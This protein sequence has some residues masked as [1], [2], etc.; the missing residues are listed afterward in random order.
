MTTLEN[1][2]GGPVEERQRVFTLVGASVACAVIV[3]GTMLSLRSGS[4]R[5]ALTTTPPATVGPATSVAAPI[6]AAATTTATPRTTTAAATD[7]AQRSRVATSSASSSVASTRDAGT[8]DDTT[9]AAA[10]DSCS[11]D[12]RGL[13]PGRT[14]SC[15]FIAREE[16]GWWSGYSDGG[17]AG[18]YQSQPPAAEVRVTHH[19]YTSYYR[20][21]TDPGTPGMDMNGWG[22]DDALIEPGDL[23]E[24]D[25]RA[26]DGASPGS[27]Y[28]AGAGRGWG[29]AGDA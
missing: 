13:A 1:R 6:G 20:A 11:V 15:Q 8:V 5:R 24:V 23:V 29:C 4:D 28:E 16:G 22:C 25:L 18:W 10:A 7:G 27:Y 26:P 19:G 17:V 3:V 9:P 12:A 2:T 14:R 21:K